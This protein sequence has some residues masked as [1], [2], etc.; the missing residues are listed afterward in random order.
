MALRLC[1]PVECRQLHLCSWAPCLLLALFLQAAVSGWDHLLDTEQC[2]APLQMH[3]AQ[4]LFPES[5]TLI[6]L[7]PQGNFIVSE[8]LTFSHWCP[9]LS[10]NHP[11][12]L[13][14]FLCVS[15]W[16]RPAMSAE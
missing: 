15:Q 11:A 7:L 12:S 14:S 5:S 1:Q 4:D 16:S 9:G 3:L 10:I 13:G 6:P 8:N 2:L